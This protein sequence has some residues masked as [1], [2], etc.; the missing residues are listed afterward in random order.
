MEK[1][2]IY[3]VECLKTTATKKKSTAIFCIFTNAEQTLA[4]VAV[5]IEFDNNKAKQWDEGKTY[6]ITIFEE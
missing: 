5:T 1:K 3:K 4:S 2:F 6:I